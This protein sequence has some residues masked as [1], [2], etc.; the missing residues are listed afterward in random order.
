MIAAFCDRMVAQTD[1]MLERW[2]ADVFDVH[3][4]LMRLTLEIIGDCLF[5][6][7]FGDD[8][9]SIST[10]AFTEAMEVIANRV[11]AVAVPPRWL[12][13]PGNRRLDRSIAALDRVVAGVIA[14][15]R[16]SGVEHED[17]LGALLRARDEHGQ[18]ID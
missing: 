16:R 17:L 8:R 12:P 2:T 4:E 3:A 5:D 18:P 10:R 13:T 9:A 11:T 7:E 1:A 15:R 14:S 6:L